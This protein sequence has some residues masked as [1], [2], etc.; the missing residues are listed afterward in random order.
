MASSKF[1]HGLTEDEYRRT[2]FIPH[3]GAVCWPLAPRVVCGNRVCQGLALTYSGMFPIH[4]ARDATIQLSLRE[5]FIAPVMSLPW[6]TVAFPS[7]R[8]PLLYHLLSR[9]PPKFPRPVH[10]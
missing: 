6:G 7:S 9:P 1:R 4:R 8:K 2:K 3:Y 10:I 5:A